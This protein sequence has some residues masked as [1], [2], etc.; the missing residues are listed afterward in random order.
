MPI[1]A[2][3]ESFLGNKPIKGYYQAIF[4]NHE[5]TIKA[6]LKKTKYDFPPEILQKLS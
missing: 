1:Y 2:I 5:D 6:F 3:T 4:K